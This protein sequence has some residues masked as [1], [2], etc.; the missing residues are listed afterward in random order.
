MIKKMA[1][2]ALLEEL[3]RAEAKFPWWPTDPIHAAAI[4]AEEAG[5]LIRAALR[6]TYEGAEDEMVTEAIQTGAMA[7]RFIIN[8][9][10]MEKANV[11]K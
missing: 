2:I 3:E 5:E 7:L 6:E 1:I 11:P 8:A 10:K 9:D 4:V